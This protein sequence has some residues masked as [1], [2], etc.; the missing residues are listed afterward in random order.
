[1]CAM[2]VRSEVRRYPPG[3]C[4]G[5]VSGRS[6]ADGAPVPGQELVETGGWVI[7]D[8]GEHVGEP[9]AGI[10]VIEPGGDHK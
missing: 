9:S 8:P 6:G 1:M 2:I 3:E 4:R 10:D 5:V 7:A